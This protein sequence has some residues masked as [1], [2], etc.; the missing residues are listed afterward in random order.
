VTVARPL[1]HGTAHVDAL[2][3]ALDGLRAQADRL[4]GWGTELAAV[5]VAG[6]RLL[7]AGNGGS[8]A[9]A[10]H[11]TSELVGRYRDDRPPF[12]AIALHAETSSCT[13]IGNDYGPDEVFA[14][15]VAAHGRPGDLLVLF[16]TSG[17]SAN[18]L[19]AARAAG[20]VGM[21]I[22]AFTGPV[23]NPLATAVDEVVVADAASTANVQELH[24]VA[25]H[26]LCAA[27]DV[28]LG[29]APSATSAGLP[30]PCTA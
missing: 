14:R 2:G 1:A 13:A 25:L 6:G 27:V 9:E 17:H 20:R 21:R 29:V 24:L 18:I 5:L 3:Q 15:Q 23:P 12:S 22:W 7:A 10:Q 4:D 19:A 11:L 28:A 26:M 8:A 16:S 30:L